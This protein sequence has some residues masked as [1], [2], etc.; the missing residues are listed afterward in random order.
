[1][2]SYICVFLSLFFFLNCL[3]AGDLSSLL[4]PCTASKRGAGG[5]RGLPV[6]DIEIHWPVG[7]GLD[8]VASPLHCSQK[9]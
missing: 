5:W 7:T 8:S 6:S 4:F 1:M 3:A 9:A 2:S